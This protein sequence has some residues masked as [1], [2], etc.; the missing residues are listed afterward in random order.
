MTNQDYTEPTNE[1]LA[2]FLMVYAEQIP[3]LSGLQLNAANL[4]QL[5]DQYPRFRKGALRHHRRFQEQID[6]LSRKMEAGE[7]LCEHVLNSGKRCP[8]HNEP[9][10]MYCGLHKE[11][12]E[13]S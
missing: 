3:E 10:S 6:E 5:M 2:S 13:P 7:L 12:E 9:G 4:E 1:Q 11:D 8:N